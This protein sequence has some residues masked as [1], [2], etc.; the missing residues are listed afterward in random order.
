MSSV[1]LF[2]EKLSEIVNS[3]DMENL[4][5][6]LDRASWVEVGLRVEVFLICILAWLAYSEV[7]WEL[8]PLQKQRE[9]VL[10]AVLVFHFS[11]F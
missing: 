6:S 8:G 10:A 4:G 3:S 11:H 5:E 7:L 2:I 1:F 9:L